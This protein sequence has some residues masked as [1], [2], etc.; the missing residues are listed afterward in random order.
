[1]GIHQFK[2]PARNLGYNIFK[3]L[4]EFVT[5][6]EVAEAFPEKPMAWGYTRRKIKLA[7]MS[8]YPPEVHPVLP[9]YRWPKYSRRDDVYSG[10]TA[11]DIKNDLHARAIELWSQTTG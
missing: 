9:D 7:F 4:R 11:F 8:N 6:N 10:T 5:H 2:I 3:F 1:M